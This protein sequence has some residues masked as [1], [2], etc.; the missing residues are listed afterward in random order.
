MLETESWKEKGDVS[1]HVQAPQEQ[2][3][4]ANR[5]VDRAGQLIEAQE[6]CLAPYVSLSYISHNYAVRY[7]AFYI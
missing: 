1:K 6:A 3:P 4:R 5:R 7:E 2:V